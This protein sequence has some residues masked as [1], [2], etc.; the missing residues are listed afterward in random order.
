LEDSDCPKPSVV[1]SEINYNANGTDTKHEWIEI[2]NNGTIAVDVTKWRFEEDG[3]QHLLKNTTSETLLKPKSYATIV[4]DE[5]QFL[6]DY[7]DYTGLLFDSSFSLVNTGEQLIL[8]MEKDGEILDSVSYN[9]TWGSDG[10]GF[11]L[12][13]LDLNGPNTQE[14]WNQSL[15]LRG[16]PGQKNSIS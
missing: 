3:T 12:E 10:N 2:Y 14:N 16:T 9:S 15:V 4:Q 5:I 7:P 8:R 6:Q 13:K 1:F 11:S